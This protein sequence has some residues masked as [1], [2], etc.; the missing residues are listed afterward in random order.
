MHHVPR[1]EDYFLTRRDFLQRCGIGF[2]ALGLAAMT[3]PQLRAD[4]VN[5]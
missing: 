2:G 5:L 3:G 1:L 4:G